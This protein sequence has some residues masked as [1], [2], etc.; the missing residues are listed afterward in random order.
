MIKLECSQ[1]EIDRQMDGQ[2]GLKATKIRSPP[3]F[4]GLVML[5]GP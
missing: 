4:V 1:K 5:V 3:R 2:M